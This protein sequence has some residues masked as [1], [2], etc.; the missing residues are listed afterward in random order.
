MT[1]VKLILLQPIFMQKVHHVN[2]EP[3][4]EKSYVRPVTEFKM[5]SSQEIT[6]D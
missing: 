4:D 5:Q 1:C 2:C 3:D 6:I